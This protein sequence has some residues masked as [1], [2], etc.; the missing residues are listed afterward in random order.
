MT[1]IEE[2]KQKCGNFHTQ[3]NLAQAL[4]DIINQHHN[5]LYEN[6]VVMPS[7]MKAG[8]HNIC[9]TLSCIING[10]SYNPGSWYQIAMQANLVVDIIKE[11]EKQ[12]IEQQKEEN[13]NAD[14]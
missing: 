4:L 1:D 3:A 5:A 6:K 14:T 10:N 8:L 13:N 12:L 2:Y 7:F 9:N 11:A